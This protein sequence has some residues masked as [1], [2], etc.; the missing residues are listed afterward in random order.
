MAALVDEIPSGGWWESSRAP[1]GA[2]TNHPFD[3]ECAPPSGADAEARNR[4]FG[5]NFGIIW[6]INFVAI[7]RIRNGERSVAGLI[8][9]WLTRAGDFAYAIYR[10]RKYAT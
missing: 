2:G 1:G 3:A 7:W 10:R 9:A 5:V 8:R 6:R 4:P